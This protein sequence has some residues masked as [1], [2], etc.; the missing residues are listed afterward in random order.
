MLS[1]PILKFKQELEELGYE[2]ASVGENRLTFPYTLREGQFKDSE[3]TLGI[4]VPPDF[5]LTAPSGPHISPRLL[6]IDPNGA[7]NRT[8]AHESANFGDEWEYLSR[9]FTQWQLKRTV[10]RYMEHVERVLETL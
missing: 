5:E 6:P 1:E 7:D 3:I 4:E 9:P 8:R 2:V 10:K